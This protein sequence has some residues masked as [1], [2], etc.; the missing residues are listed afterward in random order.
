MRPVLAGCASWGGVWGRGSPPEQDEQA[1]ARKR[2]KLLES[3][4]NA[5]NAIICVLFYVG[6]WPRG[7]KGP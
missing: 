3:V 6:G 4:A 1:T 2:S 7:S 5:C